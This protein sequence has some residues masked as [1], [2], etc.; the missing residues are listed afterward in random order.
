MTDHWWE[1]STGVSTTLANVVRP[2]EEWASGLPN[3]AYVSDE[4]ANWEQDVLLA[5]TWAC[6]GTG[7]RVPDAGDAVPLEFAGLPLIMVRGRDNEV[8]VFHNVCSHRGMVLLEE[9]ARRRSTIR[10]PYHSWTYDL[11]GSLRSTPMIGGTDKNTCEGF[12]WAKHGL[13]PVRTATWFDAIFRQ[14]K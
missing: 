14:P 8:R 6:I 3:E 1:S 9:P 13:K 5:R 7:R 10:C 12:E 4:F 2:I 11:D